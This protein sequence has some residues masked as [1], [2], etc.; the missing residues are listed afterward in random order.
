MSVGIE[1]VEDLTE[2]LSNALAKV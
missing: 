2:D 1:D